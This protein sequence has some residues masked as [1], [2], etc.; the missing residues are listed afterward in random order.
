MAKRKSSKKKSSGNVSRF[1]STVAT[2][3]DWHAIHRAAIALTWLIAGVAA[4][5]GWIYGVPRLEARVAQQAV[6][7]AQPF[8]VK[9]TGAPAWVNNE[10]RRS[11]ADVVRSYVGPDPL[12]QQDL[13]DARIAL[14]ETGCFDSVAQVRRSGNYSVEVDATFLEPFAVVKWNGRKIL[15][16]NKGRLLPPSYRLSDRA[17][18]LSITGLY[19]SPPAGPAQ[20]W[21]GTDVAAGLKLVQLL[22]PQPWSGQIDTIDLTGFMQSKPIKLITDRGSTLIWQSAPDEERAGEVSGAEK[23]RRIQF[24]FDRRGR[25]DGGYQTELDLTDPRGVFAR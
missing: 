18:F 25:V 17:H 13:I 16:D 15:I 10:L 1:F 6:D 3:F 20:R 19:Y 14:M 22:Q 4:V 12:A 7:H 11:L 24:L 5:A 9:F 2:W 8:E 21:E 23:I